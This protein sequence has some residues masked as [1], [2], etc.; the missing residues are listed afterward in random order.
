MHAH[1][2]SRPPLSY[3][4]VRANGLE[5]FWIILVSTLVSRNT[6]NNFQKWIELLGLFLLNM[7]PN[8]QI[9]KQKIILPKETG[10]YSNLQTQMQNT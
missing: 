9:L 4:I 10:S 8:L 6:R 2:L 5:M 3:T 7:L 1:F